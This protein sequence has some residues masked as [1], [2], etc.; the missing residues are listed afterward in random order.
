MEQQNV[1]YN[2]QIWETINLKALEAGESES[3]DHILKVQEPIIYQHCG[4]GG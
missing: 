1:G 4:L 2:A 3:L